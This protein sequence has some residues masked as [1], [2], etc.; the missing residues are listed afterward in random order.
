MNLIAIHGFKQSGKDTL[1]DLLVE[2]FGYTKV[3]FADRLKEAIHHIFGVDRKLLFGTEQ[4]KQK[5]SPVRWEDFNHLSKPGPDH[6]TYLSIRELL[7]IFATEI[8]REK[9]PSI[10]YRYLPIPADSKIVISDCRFKNEADF[11]KQR[12][13]ILIK[14]NRSNANS[15]NHESERGLPDEMMD[16]I[17]SN[18]LDL[19]SF[20]AD[21]RQLFLQ[22]GLKPQEQSS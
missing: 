14:V 3:A 9:I 2:E 8:C 20:L 13:T 21:G 12:N 18:N 6:P 16:Y 17:L 11:L 5:L 7:Q 19:D 22:L 15:T 4:D 1:A 10:W